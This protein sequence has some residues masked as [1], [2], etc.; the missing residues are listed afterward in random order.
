MYRRAPTLI[1][2]QQVACDALAFERLS[3]HHRRAFVRIFR[4]E[5]SRTD[6]RERLLGFARRWLHDH[7]LIIAHERRLRAMIAAPRRQHE[8]ELGPFFFLPKVTVG[9]NVNL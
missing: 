8:T 5:I 2:H 4:E 6:D 9:K 7:R 3:D 1:E